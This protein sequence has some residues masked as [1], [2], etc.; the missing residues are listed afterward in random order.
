MGARVN[1]AQVDRFDRFFDAHY[2]AMVADVAASDPAGALRR[3]RTGFASAY[4]FWAKVE[5]DGDPV[6]WVRRVVAEDHPRTRGAAG[7]GSVEEPGTPVIVDPG[8]ERHRVVALARRQRV[9]A[10]LVLGA[11]AL[12]AVGAELIV[13]HR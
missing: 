7:P 13:A 12:V 5:A 8:A 6:G 10:C 4:R 11:G 2:E 1:A 9:V 3:T